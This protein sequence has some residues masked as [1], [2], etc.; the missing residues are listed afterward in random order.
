MKTYADAIEIASSKKAKSQVYLVDN[1]MLWKDAI[2][3]VTSGGVNLKRKTPEPE[4]VV[5]TATP[6]DIHFVCDKC[7]QHLVV[8]GQASGKIVHCTNCQ[9]RVTVPACLVVT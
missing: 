5:E 3:L 9:A 8:D 7:G 6:A 4:T 2:S 1:P